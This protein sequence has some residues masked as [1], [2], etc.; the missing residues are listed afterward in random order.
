MLSVCRSELKYWI[1]YQESVLLQSELEKFLL[2][3]CYARNGFYR[4]KSLYFDSLNQ[5][6]YIDKIEG[7]EHRKKLR[8]RIYDEDT[9]W[10]KLERKQKLGAVQRKESL[11]VSKNDAVACMW[12]DYGC[13]LN[14]PENLAL[15]LYS[16]MTLGYYR[17]VVIVEYERYAFVY[18][19]YDTRITIDRH[20]RTSELELDL[21][22]K[23]LPWIHTVE[24]A[25]ILEVKF[26]GILIETIKKLLGKHHLVQ[27]AISKYGSG[28][29]VYE[30]YL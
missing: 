2:P 24:D 23:N 13:L 26:N 7:V 9:D 11:A 14:Y 16:E 18:N 3:D 6:D 22:E 25:V 30:K 19:E 20:I 27:A 15:E 1:S 5:T 17:P 12:G 29:P 8:M 10:V 21:F 28:R 4:V